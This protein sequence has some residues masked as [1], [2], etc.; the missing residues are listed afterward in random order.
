MPVRCVSD[1]SHAARAATSQPH[2]IGAGGGLVNKDKPR[3]IKKTLLSNPTPA[4]TGHV[5]S[6]LL[7]SVQAFF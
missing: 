3:R 6:M 2:H 1:Q 7:G 5:R 4:C